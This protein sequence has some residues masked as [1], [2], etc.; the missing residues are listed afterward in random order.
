MS[1]TKYDHKEVRDFKSEINDSESAVLCAEIVISEYQ[2]DGTTK[3]ITVTLP[4]GHTPDEFD[5][6][7]DRIEELFGHWTH[8]DIE[9]SFV[10]FKDGS[11]MEQQREDNM[12]TG[13]RETY[14]HLRRKPEIP[15]H[16]QQPLNSQ[17]QQ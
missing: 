7:I 12:W 2:R 15:V 11:W 17:T 14:W 8:F 6:F 5:Q 9:R 1:T 10:W 4:M 16:L 13:E 3:F